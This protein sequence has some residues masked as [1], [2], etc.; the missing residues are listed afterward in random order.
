[1]SSQETELSTSSREEAVA[2]ER[3][4][5]DE[6]RWRAE[7]NSAVVEVVEVVEVDFKLP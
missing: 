6:S 3:S 4:M 2:C 1:M 7:R 5:V